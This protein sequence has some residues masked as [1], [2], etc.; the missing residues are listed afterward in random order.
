[1]VLAGINLFRCN[2]RGD[3]DRV[4]RFGGMGWIPLSVQEGATAGLR[5]RI[6]SVAGHPALVVWEG[7]DEIIWT[8]TAYSFLERVAGFSREDW[9]NQKSIAVEYSQ[10]QSRVINPAIHEGIQLARE[11]DPNGLP[12]WINEAADS[13]VFFARE[14]VDSVDI[15]GCDY[16]AVRASGTDLPSVGRLV[17]RWRAIGLER[18]V[19]MVLQGF[20]W[21]AIKPERAKLYPSF[22]QS[23]F[24]AYDTIVHGARGVSYW[25]TNTIDDPDFR[26]SLYALTS[27][28][29]ALEPFLVANSIPSVSARIIPDLFEPPGSGVRAMGKTR[30]TDLLM[31]LVNE[32]PGRHLGVEVQGLS[33]FRG[34]RLYELYGEDVQ[35]IRREGFVTRMQGHQVKVFS[36][37]PIF[38][39][40]RKLGRDFGVP[41]QS[42]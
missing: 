24:M 33:K 42:E 18:P 14:T 27:E 26:Q 20:S 11:L 16:Y 19:W 12:F 39:S 15:L 6:E 9:N 17:D 8:Y 4:A 23:R 7:P 22:E 31:I 29:N 30:G 1:M 13:D 28:L 41:V 35:T 2:S 34:R 32:D 36:T 37:N 5:E 21:H 38:Q 3:L 40:S 25:G 10:K